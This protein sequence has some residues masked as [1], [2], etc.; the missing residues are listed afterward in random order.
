MLCDEFKDGMRD[1]DDTHVSICEKIDTIF[2]RIRSTMQAL[3]FEGL[4]SIT[5]DEDP[6][7]SLDALALEQAAIACEI[8]G[9][10][11]YDTKKCMFL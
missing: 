8:I 11:Q 6:S 2:V 3:E 4:C 7:L 1:D 9:A 10:G 5:T